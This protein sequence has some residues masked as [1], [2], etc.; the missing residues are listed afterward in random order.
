MSTLPQDLRYALRTLRRN[1]GF[2]AVAVLRLALGIGANT[3]VFSVTDYVLIRPLP[4]PSAQRLVKVWEKLP[5]TVSWS[6]PRPI[7]AIGST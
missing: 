6:C 4:F 1:P 2:A 5:A 3:A 7:I